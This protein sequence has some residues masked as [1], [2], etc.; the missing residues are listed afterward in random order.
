[1][2]KSKMPVLLYIPNIIGWTFNLFS[3]HLLENHMT[4]S[5][6]LIYPT[7]D[8]FLYDIAEGLGL[9][10][11]NIAQSRK[12]FWQRVYGDELSN[13]QLET[14]S[15]T[16]LELSDYIELLGAKRYEAFEGTLDGYY[17]PVKLGNTYALQVNCSIN[18]LDAI[19]CR[20]DK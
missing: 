18:K 5:N 15:Q 17:Y 11:N 19:C 4:N 6:T 3:F 1:M 16:E 20:T 9:V 14:F 10:D 13:A 7:I 2:S 8:L 12:N